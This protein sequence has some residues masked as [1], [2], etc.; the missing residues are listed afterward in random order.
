[1]S[2]SGLVMIRVVNPDAP[3]VNAPRVML[4]PNSNSFA[5][6]V[7]TEPLSAVALV[8]DADEVLSTGLEGSIPRIR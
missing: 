4:A 7:A 6:V 2:A 1:M 3:P 5:D 8:P